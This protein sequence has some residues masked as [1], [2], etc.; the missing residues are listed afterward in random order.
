MPR[1]SLKYT[2]SFLENRRRGLLLSSMEAGEKSCFLRQMR[3]VRFVPRFDRT[4]EQAV[5]SEETEHARLGA[6]LI[7]DASEAA[8]AQFHQHLGCATLDNLVGRLA[9]EARGTAA[10]GAADLMRA[11]VQCRK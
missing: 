9:A 6:S 11:Y 3:P 8:S 5:W 2:V 4:Q 1:G 7:T 10:R